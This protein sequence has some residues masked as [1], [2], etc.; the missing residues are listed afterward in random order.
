M[1]SSNIV[2]DVIISWAVRG[3][4][5]RSDIFTKSCMLSG[6]SPRR[7]KEEGIP[8]MN[9]ELEIRKKVEFRGR[10]GKLCGWKAVLCKG[11]VCGLLG[12][13]LILVTGFVFLSEIIFV[14]VLPIQSIPILRHP[15]SSLVYL[16]I[17]TFPVVLVQPKSSEK[18]RKKVLLGKF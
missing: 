17:F 18:K 11:F 14:Y 13:G 12:V 2:Q 8:C 15:D 9:R 3:S 7:K 5:Q 1:C 10:I 6:N 16:F 4:H